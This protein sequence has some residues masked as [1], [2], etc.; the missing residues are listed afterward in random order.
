[1]AHIDMSFFRLFHIATTIATY[2][3]D[4]PLSKAVPLNP[5]RALRWLMPWRYFS[6][7]ATGE[8]SDRTRIALESLGPLFIKFGQIISTR[9]DLLPPAV[10]EALS[11]LQDDVAPFSSKLAVARV[12]HALG[13]SV[14]ALF[15]FF[16]IQP[17]A[18]ASI[19]QV[20]V[21]TL[22]TGEKVA[23]K[24]LR[25]RVQKEVARDIKTLRLLAKWTSRL[26]PSTKR[27]R[28]GELVDELESTLALELDLRNEAANAS[29]L[30][31]HFEG[32]D[33]I[34]VPKVYFDYCAS[35]VLV[36]EFVN[37]INISD[38]DALKAAGMNFKRLAERGVEIFFTQAFEHCF[39]HADMHPGNIFVNPSRPEEPQYMAVDFG[40]MGTLSPKDQHALAENFLAFFN[41]D[42]RRVAVLHVQ[43][44][45]APADVNIE[46]FTATIRSL[47]EPIF[48]KPISEIS[49]AQSLMQLLQAS[50]AFNIEAQ[51]QLLL[52]QKTL[53][54]IEGLGRELYPDLDLWATAKPFLER[55]MIKKRHP[56]QI[57]SLLKQELPGW[58]NRQHATMPVPTPPPPVASPSYA[59]IVSFV[60]GCGLTLLIATLY[61]HGAMV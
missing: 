40:I 20:H 26:A 10:A 59:L 56:K 58:L 43:A 60:L 31:H 48:G 6:Q 2:Q 30:A 23:V 52:L 12:E 4:V 45:W 39:F 46:A 49:F 55:W 11:H 15:Q 5:F 32:S 35:E 44:G 53:F 24:I 22:H 37:G 3:I 19:S 51:P 14:S 50:R 33:L 27:F 54:N 18:A 7:K 9:R 21:A 61:G 36:T 1:M 17:I 13:Q 34:H 47:C 38:I 28:L 16:D 29:L 25:P 8:F 41:R 42:Y 57:L